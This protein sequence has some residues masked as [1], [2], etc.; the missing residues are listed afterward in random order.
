MAKYILIY[1][2][3]FGNIYFINNAALMFREMDKRKVK[4]AGQGLCEESTGQDW[5]FLVIQ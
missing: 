5:C 1:L 4:K 3:C 2:K